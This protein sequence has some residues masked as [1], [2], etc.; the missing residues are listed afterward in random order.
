MWAT[1]VGIESP[2]GMVAVMVI[3]YVPS[4]APMSACDV[5][6][7]QKSP[8]DGLNPM[9]PVEGNLEHYVTGPLSFFI[10]Q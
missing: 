2:E 9:A 8:L 4:S 5:D 7:N 1:N 6:L 10:E 3:S